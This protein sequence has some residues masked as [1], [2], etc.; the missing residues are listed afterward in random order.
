MLSVVS[1]SGSSRFHSQTLWGAAGSTP[2]KS[3]PETIAS[4]SAAI[5]DDLPTPPGENGRRHEL[6]QQEV[7][8]EPLAAPDGGGV[9]EDIR[10]CEDRRRCRLSW[11]RGGARELD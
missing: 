8:V 3:L 9:R 11:L 5:R 7:P 4:A 1:S 2:S 6:T 10:G